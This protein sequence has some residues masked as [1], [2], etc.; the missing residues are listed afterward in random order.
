MVEPCCGRGGTSAWSGTRGDGVTLSRDASRFAWNGV[1]LSLPEG[2]QPAV[3]DKEYMVAEDEHG[4]VME[5]KWRR[6]RGRFS[7]D[8]HVKRLA[9]GVR[10]AEVFASDS[11]TNSA[12][13]SATNTSKVPEDWAETVACK[14]SSGFEFRPFFWKASDLAVTPSSPISGGRGA[15]LFNPDSGLACL[16]QFYETGKRSIKDVAKAALLS[17][18]DSSAGDSVPWQVF[19][20][21]LETPASWVLAEHSFQPG[22]FRMGF[23]FPGERGRSRFIAERV[24]PARTVLGQV[25][26]EEWAVKFYAK[27]LKGMKTGANPGEWWRKPGLVS[28]RGA[29]AR[30]RLSGPMILAGFMHR[31]SKGE[32]ARFAQLMDGYGRVSE[33]A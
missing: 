19:G 12:T 2:W 25:P 8:R 33:E 9:K 1:E 29:A 26:L 16:I 22:R 5:L 4:P 27:E 3:L 11:A 30:V 17:L 15:V 32:L 28:R 23:R 18:R 21:T 7:M 13:G 20:I 14:E 10:G 24:A 6:V 31:A